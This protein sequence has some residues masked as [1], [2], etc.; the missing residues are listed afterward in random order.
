LQQQVGSRGSFGT[1]SPEGRSY[2]AGLKNIPVAIVMAMTVTMVVEE[3]TKTATDR[4]QTYAA[5]RRASST[6]RSPPAAVMGTRTENATAFVAAAATKTTTI[7]RPVSAASATD[8]TYESQTTQEPVRSNR[9]RTRPIEQS[10]GHH[11][12]TWIVEAHRHDE[13]SAGR[14]ALPGPRD[15]VPRR[16]L[17][18]LAQ[19]W[20]AGARGRPEPP[21]CPLADAGGWWSARSVAAKGF[22]ERILVGAGQRREGGGRRGSGSAVVDGFAHV[23]GTDA[24]RADRV[25]RALGRQMGEGHACPGLVDMLWEM[26]RSNGPRFPLIALTWHACTSSG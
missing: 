21:Q 3:M 22:L 11:P 9:R 17:A 8:P 25:K 13:E 23:H 19:P 14:A 26:D 15:E 10:T 16:V 4:A 6:A 5:A 1:E 24:P 2:I 18:R 12:P 7:R 20:C